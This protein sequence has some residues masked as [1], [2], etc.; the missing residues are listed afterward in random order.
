MSLNVQ[1]SPET[2]VNLAICEL[3]DGDKEFYTHVFCRSNLGMTPLLHWKPL[4][5]AARE[6][7]P[8]FC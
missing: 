6:G 3:K 8:R 7:A 4:G 1:G 2:S 5:I